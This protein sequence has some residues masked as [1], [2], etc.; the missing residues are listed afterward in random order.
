M[1]TRK[2]TKQRK[3]DTSTRRRTGVRAGAF[4]TGTRTLTAQAGSKPELL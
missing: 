4:G 2:Q 1:T 3:S